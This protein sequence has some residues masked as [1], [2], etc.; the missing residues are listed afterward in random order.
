MFV[1][2]DLIAQEVAGPSSTAL[3]PLPLG[4]PSPA[5]P[6][7]Q[8]VQDYSNSRLQA[9]IGAMQA[10]RPGYL[11]WRHIF[12]I[13][14][15][16]IAYG[17]AEDGRLLVTFPAKGNWV[18]AGDWKDP[19]LAASLNGKSLPRR[20]HDRRKKTAELLEP[21]TGPLLHNPTRGMFL[22]QNVDRY[23]GFL[24]QWGAIYERFGV[25]A[26]IGLAQAIIESGLDGRARS[27]A[28][29]L[30]FCQFLSRNWDH[31]N[32]LAP[33]VIEAFNQTTQAPF[34][35]GYLSI[36]ATM[37]DSFVPALSE[38]HAGGVNVGRT[39]ING[40]RL[41]GKSPRD[42]YLLGS[43]FASKLRDISIRRFRELFRTYG[44]R[45]FLYAEMVLGN[46]LNVRRLI[47]ETPQEPIYA[48]RVS[49]AVSL[50]EITRHT[51]LSAAEV[52]RYNP[53]LVKR[54]PSRATLYL[55]RR[56]PAFGSDVSFWH[57][58][59]DPQYAVVLNEFL[60]L[61]PGV[62]RWH[63]ASFEATL[64]GFEKR[65]KATDSEE[66][67]VMA[68][69]LAYVIGDLTTSRR[70]AILDEFATSARV[71]RLFQQGVRELGALL[72]RS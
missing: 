20:L 13:P 61:E 51:G 55:P 33:Y 23:G 43:E 46:M 6:A 50:T 21:I 4:G 68:T 36:L 12:T 5:S 59:A 38:H 69:V 47:Q 65:F 19:G 10:F 3:G 9:D 22:L 27:R 44:P 49:R 17:S 62:Q 8:A 54:V 16:R 30:G 24:S 70:A 34:C 7:E 41:G 40:A 60:R 29:A 42:R 57:R 1:T 14:D 28:R 58:P 31:I 66:G 15:G 56:I 25:P 45:S 18:R 52:K 53:A 64:R 32:R 39:V 37:Y 48:M 63:D 35:A 2:M 26:E 67:T 71:L 11:F 72:P